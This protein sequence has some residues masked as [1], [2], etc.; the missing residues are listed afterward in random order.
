MQG[1][2]LSK[3]LTGS[4]DVFVGRSRLKGVNMMPTGAA[5]TVVFKDGGSGG[6]ALLTLNTPVQTAILPHYVE[7]PGEGILFSTSIY[8]VM[9]DVSSITAFFG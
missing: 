3:N 8:A 2:V 9:T 6:T 7:I 5:G 1:D 4:G